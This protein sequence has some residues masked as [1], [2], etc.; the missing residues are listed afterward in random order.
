MNDAAV[1]DSFTN[2][3]PAAALFDIEH[4][5][6]PVTRRLEHASTLS[7]ADQAL[8]GQYLPRVETL[9][10]YIGDL[11]PDGKAG[12]DAM[13]ADLETLH[14]QYQ[15]L[16]RANLP[17]DEIDLSTRPALQ[18]DNALERRLTAPDQFV[19]CRLTS[20]EIEIL[21]FNPGEGITRTPIQR[22][23]QGILMTNKRMT[24]AIYSYTVDELRHDLVNLFKLTDV[25]IPQ[26]IAPAP[27]SDYELSPENTE[28]ILDP[29]NR[30]R[31]PDNR[32]MNH[33]TLEELW[34]STAERSAE[35]RL[36]EDANSYD[37]ARAAAR[38][39]TRATGTV[40][41][42]SGA[43]RADRR[44]IACQPRSGRGRTQKLGLDPTPAHRLRGIL[45]RTGRTHAT[46]LTYYLP[47][48][49]PICSSSTPMARCPGASQTM[50]SAW[51]VER[52]QTLT[53]P[54]AH[55]WKPHKKTGLKSSPRGAP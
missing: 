13:L 16:T 33:S 29:A 5:L 18:V 41:A 4:F 2:S 11:P 32:E 30:L 1:Y 12:F 21:R 26:D 31:N 47:S 24:D 22:N 51:I 17:P 39:P 52:P 20:G 25:S 40:H 50:S 7:S 43:V 36:R 19:L 37:F 14:T 53:T 8:I 9:S 38:P 42:G 6:E 23:D 44:T 3:K 15:D 45:A 35:A 10:Q 28:I 27:L 49:K 48:F 34:A 46:T 54:I 55:Y